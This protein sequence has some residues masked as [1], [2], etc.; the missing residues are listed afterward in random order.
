MKQE[1]VESLMVFVNRKL[2]EK[3]VADGDHEAA[4]AALD[5]CVLSGQLITAYKIKSGIK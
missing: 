3:G 1:R 5:G 4:I 2:S